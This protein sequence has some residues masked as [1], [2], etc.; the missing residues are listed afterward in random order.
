MTMKTAFVVAFALLSLT[1]QT[2]SSQNIPMPGKP[3]KVPV[4]AWEV[5]PST[6]TGHYE[7]KPS[8]GTGNYQV[9][10]STGAAEARVCLEY[11]TWT[12]EYVCGGHTEYQTIEYLE[13]DGTYASKKVPVQV[14]D[15]CTRELQ[16]CVK[17]SR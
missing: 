9:K 5:K 6:G 10:P 14:E 17:W 15:K 8:T 11:K 7:V 3:E 16:K 12:V 2:A 13:P 4:P 1:S